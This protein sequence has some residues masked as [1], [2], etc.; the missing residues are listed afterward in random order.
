MKRRNGAV[1]FLATTSTSR[2]VEVLACQTALEGGFLALEKRMI[3]DSFTSRASMR[4]DSAVGLMREIHLSVH[5]ALVQQDGKGQ[6]NKNKF[7]H[8][9]VAR[10]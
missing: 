3:N 5:Q 10:K 2:D 4:N 7:H 9:V 8:G 6:E 1:G